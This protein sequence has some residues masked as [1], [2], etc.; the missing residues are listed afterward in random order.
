M[1]SAVVHDK[2]ISDVQPASVIRIREKLIYIVLGDLNVAGIFDPEV[3]GSPALRKIQRGCV[4]SR[5]RLE[6]LEVGQRIPVSFEVCVCYAAFQALHFHRGHG[7]D[8]G[9][10]GLRGAADRLIS[11]IAPCRNNSCLRQMN[12]SPGYRR[13][14]PWS[15]A[16]HSISDL[17]IFAA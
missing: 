4:S 12:R 7:H 2:R 13:A 10:S 16:V 8:F 14:W 15:V 17:D 3:F 11:A 5:C 6:C 1:K 9:E